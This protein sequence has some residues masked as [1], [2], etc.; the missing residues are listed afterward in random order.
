MEIIR[1]Q[2][3]GFPAEL[4]PCAFSLSV[5]FPGFRAGAAARLVDEAALRL[6]GILLLRLRPRNLPRKRRPRQMVVR[7]RHHL[8]AR[9][10]DAHPE[11]L[12]SA[13][14]GASSVGGACGAGG[15]GAVVQLGELG[16]DGH[17]DLA[18]EAR[19]LPAAALAKGEALLGGEVEH[20]RQRESA[21]GLRDPPGSTRR[22]GGGVRADQMIPAQRLQAITQAIIGTGQRP[23]AS[24]LR[25]LVG[26]GAGVIQLSAPW[27]RCP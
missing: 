27:R 3:G 11:L 21:A 6:P 13:A 9:P 5:R 20:G 16:L 14:A 19:G 2:R 1:G 22:E 24:V 23:H 17:D 12:P 15:G 4:C 26:L 18:V 25:E 8:L 10:L 7:K